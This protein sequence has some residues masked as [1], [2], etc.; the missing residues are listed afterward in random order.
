MRILFFMTITISIV[1]SDIKIKISKKNKLVHITRSEIIDLY[2]KKIDNIKGIKVVPIDN[3]NS[4]KEFYRK[5]IKKTPKQ[6]RAYWIKSDKKRPPKRLSTSEI[7]KEMKKNS[8]I[9]SYAKNDLTGKLLFRI[10]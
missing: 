5:F 7:N 3:K 4:Y 8:K 1:F 10:D 9:L 2:L 6:L